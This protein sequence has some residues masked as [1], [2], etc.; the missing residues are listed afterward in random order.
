[1]P[2]LIPAIALA[3]AAYAVPAASQSFSDEIRCFDTDQSM[4]ARI[5]DVLARDNRRVAGASPLHI[6][7][8]RMTSARFDCK[9]GHAARGL[10]AYAAADRELQAI[11]QGMRSQSA[12]SDIA[13]TA[14]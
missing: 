1:M 4:S 7:L 14:R 11:E 2:R 10:R 8:T 9:H 12:R 5:R 6:V 13:E 3:V